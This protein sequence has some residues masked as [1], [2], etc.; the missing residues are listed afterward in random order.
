LVN[1][2]LSNKKPIKLLSHNN[3]L[4]ISI[5]LLLWKEGSPDPDSSCPNILEK[6]W[7]HLAGLEGVTREGRGLL[8]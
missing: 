3:N 1:E 4:R 8:L 2:S 5:I 7:N 6:E